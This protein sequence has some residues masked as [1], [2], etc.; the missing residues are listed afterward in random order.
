MRILIGSS[1]FVVLLLLISFDGT[2][3][4]LLCFFSNTCFCYLISLYNSLTNSHLC[5]LSENAIFI[6]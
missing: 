3:D 1:T 4:G 6:S 5:F 2:D